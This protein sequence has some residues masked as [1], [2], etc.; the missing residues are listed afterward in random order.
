[1][2]NVVHAGGSLPPG[3]KL[4]P[5]V[6]AGE[7]GSGG[8]GSVYR[9]RD[10]RLDRDVALKVIRSASATDVSRRRRFEVEARAAA[11]VTHPN[12]VAVYDVGEDSGTPYIVSELVNGGTLADRMRRD[13]MPLTE[14]MAIAIPVAEGLAEAHR[15]GVVHRDLKPENILLT[16][17]GTP[18]ISDF[19]LSKFLEPSD[20]PAADSTTA[21]APITVDGAIL[22]TPS[23][24]SPEQA[25]GRDADYRADQFA[26]G[27]VL[28]EMVTGQSPF[29]RSSSVQT[30][31]AVLSDEIDGAQLERATSPA[32]A[33]VVKRCVAK[34]PK[35]RYGSTDDLVHDLRAA[36]A[37]E[38]QRKSARPGLIAAAVGIAIAI[39]VAA[40]ILLYRS[41][42][43]GQMKIES[44]AILPLQNFSGDRSQD[45]F[46]D[47]LT[48]E[49]TSQLASLRA[50][51]VTSR[52]SASAYRGTTKQ[53]SAVARELGV[54]AVIEG[55]V[56][57]SADAARVTIQLIDGRT[58]RHLW[59]QSFD[60]RGADVLALERDIATRIAE[61]IRVTLSPAERARIE[62]LP[63][64]NA[65]A[66]DA[67]LHSVYRERIA[68]EKE[69]EVDAALRYA[70]KAVALDPNFAEGYVAMA[71]SCGSKIFGYNGGKEYDEKGFV[72]IEKALSIN[73]SL[74]EAY[75]AR[76]GLQY[77]HWHNY[78]IAAAVTD[79]RRAIALNPNSSDAH[80][81]VGS[82][83]THL[84]RHREAIAEFEKAISLDPKAIG[85]KFRMA[86]AQ[87]Q[88][89]QFAEALQTFDRY[90]TGGFEKAVT[91]AYLGRTSDAWAEVSH[92]SNVPSARGSRS[93]FDDAS[94]RALLHAMAGQ[95]DEAAEE[96]ARSA[97]L[98]QKDPHFHHAAFL[99]AAAA[100]ELGQEHEAVKWLQFAA[101]SGMPNYP[102]FRENPSMKKLQGKPEYES[103]M[104]DLKLRWDQ[105]SNQIK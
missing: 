18:K 62:T 49:I 98:G 23:Y 29:R 8:M 20:R 37:D 97:E 60:A 82:E 15:A 83:L 89:N 101:N 34:D 5:Y 72:A 58:D 90:A 95:H 68:L 74:A 14:A 77:N 53:L 40:L 9:A 11:R 57:R 22:G 52:T 94:A 39:I 81:L 99:L 51:R 19:G 38:T 59:A 46:A 25:A 80:A 102:L 96:S 84:G 73:P 36:V 24:M 35:N 33:A 17:S 32:I 76:G 54:D 55:S 47:G 1:M 66:Y 42:T 71:R 75:L 65:E 50:L 78:D 21:V 93:A 92:A 103:F 86:R 91:L 61:E 48:D 2:T 12:L 63:T 44:L 28:I 27:V 7:I 10:T 3:A 104:A 13:R 70:E 67:Y 16:T 100:A 64:S 85:P 4:G 43:A 69:E 31:A 79:Y 56:V 88:S 6:I 26:F 87:W 105:I 30:L 45:Y 41:R